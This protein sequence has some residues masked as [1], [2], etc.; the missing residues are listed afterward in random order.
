MPEKLPSTENGIETIE[1]YTAVPGSGESQTFERSGTRAD[2]LALY[3]E[4]LVKPLGDAPAQVT[5][6]T[7]KGRGFLT[8]NYTRK[9]IG[10][11]PQEDSVQELYAFDVVRDIRTAAYFASLTNAEIAAVFKFWEDQEIT[12]AGVALSAPAGWSELQKSL[13]GHVCRGQESYAE[14]AHEFRETFQTTSTQTL[15]MAAKNP[16]RV[17]AEAAQADHRWAFR[18]R[19]LA[20]A[21]EFLVGSEMECDIR[22]QFYGA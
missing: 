10:I 11:G 19:G 18:A 13:F 16:N 14:T 20:C 8:E 4:L 7:Q 17:V 3:Q 12:F 5:L 6:R 22:R 1:T 15:K 9:W 21:A 2:M